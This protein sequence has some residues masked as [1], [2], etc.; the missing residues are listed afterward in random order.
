VPCPTVSSSAVMAS[1]FPRRVAGLTVW[2]EGGR[3]PGV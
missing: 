3:F 1:A 2:G